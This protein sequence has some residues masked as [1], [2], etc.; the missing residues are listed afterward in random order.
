M[1]G[2]ID[3]GCCAGAIRLSIIAAAAAPASWNKF[4]R[5]KD[6]DMVI[7]LY[8]S[9]SRLAYIENRRQAKRKAL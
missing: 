6:L 3:F 2:G 5:E 1:D 7:L 9:C 8:R 4:L